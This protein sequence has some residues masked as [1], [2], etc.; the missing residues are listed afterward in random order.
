MRSAM[1]EARAAHLAGATPDQRRAFFAKTAPQRQQLMVA[2]R[3]LAAQIQQVLTPDQ[4]TWLA[5]HRP[6]FK[7]NPAM[8]HRTNA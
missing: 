8:H 1:K 4:R 6:S 2:N 3:Q 5:S 7:R